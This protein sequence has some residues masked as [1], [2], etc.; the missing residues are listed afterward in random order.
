MP[1]GHA[2]EGNIAQMSVATV[3]TLL[4]MERRSGVLKVSSGPRKCVLEI[5][6]GYAVGGAIDDSKVSPLAV[7]RDILRWQDGRFR[8]RPGTDGAVPTNKRSI[9]ALLI[10]AV[11]L[12]DES[13]RDNWPEEAQTSRRSWPV[14][15]PGGA[16][17]AQASALRRASRPPPPGRPSKPPP[18]AP[19]LKPP[20]GVG[21]VAA[22]KPPPAP[23]LKPPPGTGPKPASGTGPK[24]PP[25]EASKSAPDDASK[26]APRPMTKGPPRPTATRRAR[27]APPPTLRKK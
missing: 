4:E 14:I 3:L 6:A 25:A 5:V 27:P 11:R 9:G 13:S 10:E 8:F 7:L 23:G 15:Q 17:R 24:P 16:K 20:P 21:P 22:Q 26:S 1:G 18:P 19:G 12:D 2:I